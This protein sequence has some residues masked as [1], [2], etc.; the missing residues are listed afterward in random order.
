MRMDCHATATAAARNDKVSDFP[1]IA[2]LEKGVA[3]H[4][5]ILESQAEKTHKG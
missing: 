4:N 5:T 3:I 2:S 1:I